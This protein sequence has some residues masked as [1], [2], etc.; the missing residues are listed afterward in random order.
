MK[1]ML[2]DRRAH[3][4]PLLTALLL[5]ML[6]LSLHVSADSI[7]DNLPTDAPLPAT[8]DNTAQ[9]DV[10][11]EFVAVPYIFST[12]TLSVATGVAG[13][14]KH[15][16]Q[17]Q[18]SA[19]G[20]ALYTSNDSWVA[21]LGL[22]NYL[23]PGTEQW[24]FSAETYQGHYTEGIYY[25]P[26]SNAA[27]LSPEDTQRIVT[28]GDEG[29]SKLHFSY[30]L[31]MGHGAQGA[32]NSLRPVKDNIHWNPLASGVTSL[33]ITPFSKR[34][35][36]DIPAKLPDEARG[37][38]LRLNWDNRD[39]ARNSTVGG[40][41]TLTVNRDFGSNTRSSWTT[42]EFEQSY[43]HDLGASHWFQEQVLALDFYLADTPTWD[44]DGEEISQYHRP[45]AFAGVT[46]GGFDRL[47]GFS[48]KRFA[49]RSAVDY[50]VEYRM[51][52][53][54]QPLQNWPV[55]RWYTVPWWQWVVFAE[56]GKVSNEFAFDELHS[57]MKYTYGG[58]IRFEIENLVVRTELAFGG[59]ESQIWV[60]VNQPF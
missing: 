24:L 48:G 49:G 28:V 9:A 57:D 23:I 19:F 33:R 17:V 2:T 36:L 30:V 29:F 21:Y 59:D 13:V 31:P 37:V 27:N 8:S 25:L 40:E 41:T 44:N 20:L 42:W 3:R 56:A 15:A 26:I 16:G 4:T 47:R 39:N 51:K 35:E 52:P 14:I 46:L 54:W 32:V 10:G 60:M 12:E 50:A 43:F 55:F 45:P 53:Q 5:P 1:L 6:L 7:S 18:A 22:N 34:Q 11:P 38:S 58:A